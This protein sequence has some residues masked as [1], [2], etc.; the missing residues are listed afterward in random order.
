MT[1]GC[2]ALAITPSP[3]SAQLRN[4]ISDLFIFGPG[5]APLFLAGSGDPNNPA[6]LQAHG[7]HFIPSSSAE[8]GAL[9]SF[10]TD[11]LG[12]SVGRIPIG[13]TSGGETFRFE[14]GVPVR[15]ST[16]AGPIF[17]ERAQTLGRGRVLAGISRT[18]FSFATLRGVDINNLDLTFT[19]QN[20]DFEG[21][22]AEF[23]GDCSLHGV[24]ELENDVME[25]HLSMNLDVS[26]TSMY[27]TYGVTDRLDLGVVVP[28][29]QAEF[30]G[31]SNA[32][33]VPFGGASAAH[34]FGGDAD[35]PVLSAR[36]QSF[37]SAAGLGDV[38]LRAKL[39]LRGTADAGFALLLDGRFP[40]GSEE[41][42][43][44]AGK[45]SGRTLM[46]LNT[47]FGDFSP[48]V[49]V[50]YLHH[51]GTQQ[52]DAVLGTLGFDHRM[53]DTFTLA[54]DLVAE[55]QV[56]DS[57]LPL[58]GIVTYEAPFRRTVNPTNIPA[59][60]DDIVNGS[61]GFKMIPARSTTLVLNTLF[62]LNRGG[63]RPNLVYT[64]GIEY[65]F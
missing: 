41:D 35:H 49:N 40:T 3:A 15:T 56:G 13:S 63:L 57:R 24:P 1:L 25:F 31:E 4:K 17:A 37:G 14:G 21:C 43:L 54:A 34:F 44:G 8:N 27:F 58:P 19:H 46:I 60:R 39:N 23:G 11:A 52:N 62:P 6:S 16:S 29:V 10:I 42:L 64:A 33:M 30:R 26:V 45:F 38:A 7:L 53:S 51:A 36:R 47:R 28:I 59:V 9:I 50:G 32:Q 18:G 20:V 22:D 12:S 65:T 55:L 61:F 5:E 2:V 48:H